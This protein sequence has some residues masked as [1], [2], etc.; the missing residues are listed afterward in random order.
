MSYIKFHCAEII[1]RLV[2]IRNLYGPKECFRTRI[3]I[4]RS[5]HKI[6]YTPKPELEMEIE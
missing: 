3:F 1:G 5:R 2:N 4:C 6:Q